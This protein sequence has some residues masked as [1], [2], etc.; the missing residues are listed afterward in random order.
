MAQVVLPVRGRLYIRPLE[1]ATATPG[2]LLPDSG[3]QVHL[4]FKFGP[5]AW[6]AVEAM[7]TYGFGFRFGLVWIESGWRRNVAL[8]IIQPA[9]GRD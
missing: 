4:E 7:K 1:I 5:L 2:A 6:M 3:E 9:C 8:E